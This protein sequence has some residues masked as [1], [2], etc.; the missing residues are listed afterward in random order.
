M[1]FLLA[2]LPLGA[3]VAVGAAQQPVPGKSV[4]SGSATLV[5]YE[6]GPK[7]GTPLVLLSGG[8]GFDSDYFWYGP[9]FKTLAG[10]RRVLTYDQRG[11]GRS[12]PVGPGDT[13][14]VADFV[15]DLEA[16][17]AGLGA[18]KL[19]LLGHSWGGYLAIAYAAAHGDRIA[20]LLLIDSAAPK[21]SDTIFLFKQAFPERDMNGP[22]ERG[23]AA[24][25][26]AA[27]NSALRTYLSMIFY[28]PEHRDA[29]VSQAAKIHYNHYQ[30]G[31][32]SR[33]L[34]KLDLTPSL[35]SFQFPTLVVTGRYDMNVAP[36]TAYRMHQAIPGSHFVVFERS[37]HI[38]FYEEPEAFV[39]AVEG[40]LAR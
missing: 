13:V 6:L 12:S 27:I 23:R 11:T 37:S 40:F 35:A 25:D 15:A 8:P 17:R 9:A 34:A 31:H 19:D 1:K 5:Y 14:T 3:L 10:K 18:A 22:F 30:S 28:S 21:F 39:A 4:R 20:H 26:T 7:T 33:D 24:N 36:L 16:L 29:F 32:L 38:P 2:V